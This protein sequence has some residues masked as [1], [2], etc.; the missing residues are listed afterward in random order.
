MK[1]AVYEKSTGEVVFS[2][3]LEAD[4]LAGLDLEIYSIEEVVDAPSVLE[5]KHSD[6]EF[7]KDPENIQD[8][9][10]KQVTI[11]DLDA[12]LKVLEQKVL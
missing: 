11:E 9:K 1:K 10:E 8:A 2:G 6:G 7:K 3:D 5:F 4:F 12:R